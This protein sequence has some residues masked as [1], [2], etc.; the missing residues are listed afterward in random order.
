MSG[1]WWLDGAFAIAFALVALLFAS[2][3][4]TSRQDGDRAEPAADTAHLLMGIGMV[5]MFVPPADPL[6]GIAWILIFVVSSVWVVTTLLTRQEGSGAG[7]LRH[8]L[9]SNVGMIYMFSA[10][11]TGSG[12][13]GHTEHVAAVAMANGSLAHAHGAG[14]FNLTPLTIAF[15]GYFLLHAVRTAIQMIRAG[16]TNTESGTGSVALSAPPVLYGVR[17][18]GSSHV[19]MGL[20]MSYMFAQ[21][22]P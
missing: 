9:I 1:P 14:S 12:G 4:I 22:L 5:V 16:A 19:V 7:H 15:T 6:P 11:G 17:T 2:R 3:L 18:V 21:M 20:G 10:M 8:V 13:G